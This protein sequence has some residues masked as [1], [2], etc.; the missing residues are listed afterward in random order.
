MNLVANIFS[1]SLWTRHSKGGKPCSELSQHFCSRVWSDGTFVFILSQLLKEHASSIPK[2][3]S[4][5]I[6]GQF[7]SV[8]SMGADES[9]WLCSEFKESLVTPGKESRTPGS[10][11]PLHLVSASPPWGHRSYPLV[12][13][14]NQVSPL[15]HREMFHSVVWGRKQQYISIVICNQVALISFGAGRLL[16]CSEL[17][18]SHRLGGE[19]SIP[20]FR[21]SS[22]G[23]KYLINHCQQNYKHY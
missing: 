1:L 22:Q 11:V 23:K 9:K 2:A 14:K 7:S 20:S 3:E 6:V 13:E 19:F 12:Q 21:S 4:W 16:V 5:P 17:H 8:G 18:L 10:T 15:C